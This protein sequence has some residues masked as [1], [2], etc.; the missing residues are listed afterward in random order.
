ML[1]LLPRPRWS[2]CIIDAEILPINNEIASLLTDPDPSTASQALDD[3]Q[4]MVF[5]QTLRKLSKF[6]LKYFIYYLDDLSNNLVMV[7]GNR[8]IISFDSKKIKAL[9]RQMAG[10][11]PPP[12][13]NKR[14]PRAK[15]PSSSSESSYSSLFRLSNDI[16][17]YKNNSM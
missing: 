6:Q 14:K 12:K 9:Q 4:D 7:L 15:V 3:L 11:N 1:Q 17:L 16:M 13:A 5:D 2:L 8:N 10:I